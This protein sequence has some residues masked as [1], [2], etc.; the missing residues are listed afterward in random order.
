MSALTRPV[1]RRTSAVHRVDTVAQ[2][3]PDPGGVGHP[4]TVGERWPTNTAARRIDGRQHAE[5][6]RGG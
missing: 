4:V 5:Q 3:A 1:G 2:A 6:P